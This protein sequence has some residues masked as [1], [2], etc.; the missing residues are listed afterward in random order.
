MSASARVIKAPFAGSPI[1]ASARPGGTET[2][3]NS[4]CE[5]LSGSLHPNVDEWNV[6]RDRIA[7]DVMSIVREIGAE[8]TQ[9]EILKDEAADEPRGNLQRKH[10]E[11]RI[12]IRLI[13]P[14]PAVATIDAT[15]ATVASNSTTPKIPAI[16]RRLRTKSSARR[17][18]LAHLDVLD[19]DHLRE[20]IEEASPA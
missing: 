10:G 16:S 1:P 19:R 4:S 18:A 2:C 14:N 13:N 9:R 3:R 12:G 17:T 8:R 5:T 15:V 20:Q 6:G 7:R 11:P